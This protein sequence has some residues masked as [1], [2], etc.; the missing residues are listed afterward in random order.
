VGSRERFR[1]DSS[2]TTFWIFA[3]S[4]KL[5]FVPERIRVDRTRGPIAEGPS[6]ATIQVIDA[7]EKPSYF[8]DATGRLRRRPR[9]PYPTDGPRS[10]RPARPCD[11]SFTHLV[12]G[13]R[14]FSAAMVYAV[15]R[16]TLAVW[17]H[18]FQLDRPFAWHFAV[19][20]DT[21]LQIHPRV[22]SNN[23]WSGD[24][25]LE[26]GFPDW[27]ENTRDP[28]CENFE[29]IAHETGHLILK[30]VIGTMPNDE[31]SLQ[32]RAHEEGAADLVALITNLHV[33]SVIDHV[34]AQT[35]GFLYSDNL[36]SRIGEWGRGADDVARTAFNEATMASVRS[37]PSPNK[38]QLS[39]PFTGAVYDVFV[40]AFVGH[41]RAR[42]AI[43]A[44]LAA[45]CR[46]TPGRPVE[47]LAR[48]FA[49]ARARHPE[50]FREAL[51]LTRDDLGWLLA[52]AWRRTGLDGVTYGKVLSH[53]LEAD[54]ELDTG[55]G[56]T[57]RDAFHA[58][59]I[60]PTRAHPPRLG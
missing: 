45:R 24:G 8:S 31:K 4:R 12:P 50:A 53:L 7:L 19:S 14:A 52:G 48:S 3:Q 35:G 15:V 22:E 39:A 16:T 57:I 28:F 6:D 13:Q 25:F 51:R 37:L 27:D 29:V 55:L 21:V 20:P 11:G 2:G 32:H 9:P 40:R 10:S 43:D 36:L 26:F 38:H 58:R 33:D 17:Q 47:P 60:V 5:G 30:S 54:A 44:G 34:L 18:F 42:D 23:A 56:E 41:L 49:A 46:H 59:G 1:F